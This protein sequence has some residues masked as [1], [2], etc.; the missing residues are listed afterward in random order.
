MKLMLSKL[1]NAP[2]TIRILIILT[3]LASLWGLTVFFHEAM[4]YLG[5]KNNLLTQG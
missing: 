3:L 1:Q 2:L 4:V 5:V